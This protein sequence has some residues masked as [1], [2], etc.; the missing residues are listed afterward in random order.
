HLSEN[1][2]SYAADMAASAL[3]N[4]LN[5]LNMGATGISVRVEAGE[6]PVAQVCTGRT[7]CYNPLR[8]GVLITSNTNGKCTM[9]FHF[10]I[11]SSR[12]FMTSGHCSGTI[13]YHYS[14]GVLGGETA[15]NLCQGSLPHNDIKRVTLPFN[16]ATSGVY[17]ASYS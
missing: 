15:N 6:Q 9:G 1:L 7:N 17:I 4:T 8:P 3:N 14:Y 11:G 16:Q 5:A 12:L 2:S 10:T 13:H